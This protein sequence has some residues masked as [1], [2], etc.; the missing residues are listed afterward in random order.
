GSITL[1]NYVLNAGN[2]S[3]YQSNI[4][5]GCTGGNTVGNTGNGCV[6]FGGAPFGWYED[7][8]TQAAGGDSS[9]VNYTGGSAAA[10]QCG[11]PR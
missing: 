2:T 9:P 3:L 6:T 5:F 7:P 4:P 8:A 10:G 1:H 11:K